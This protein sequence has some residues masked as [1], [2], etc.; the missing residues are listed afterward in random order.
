LSERDFSETR[1]IPASDKAFV[2]D[3]GIETARDRI[4]RATVP[5]VSGLE[6]FYLPG[7]CISSAWSQWSTFMNRVLPT[8]VC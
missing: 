8:S 7:C 1:V 6:S 5:R 2:L 4:E 3:A